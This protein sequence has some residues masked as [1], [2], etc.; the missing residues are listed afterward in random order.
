MLRHI[1]HDLEWAI[2]CA[3]LTLIIF[4]IIANLSIQPAI[5]DITETDIAPGKIHCRSEQVL[6][7]E[8]GHKW[9]VMFF[10]Q[11][12]SSQTASLDLRLSGL[13]S[14]IGIQSRK[15]LV[16][17]NLSKEIRYEAPDIF[18][19]RSPL[20]SIGQYDLKNILSQLPKTDLLLELPLENGTSTQLHIPKA[21]VQEWHE[22]A[23]KKPNPSQK[24]PPSI[25]LAC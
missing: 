4:L 9:D 14:A 19:S 2:A 7:D 23:S 11:V 5:A 10:T 25:E 12:D 1:L 13:S 24:F 17:S 6:T 21:I 8:A 20:P 16:I 15:P 3:I 18:L 22:V